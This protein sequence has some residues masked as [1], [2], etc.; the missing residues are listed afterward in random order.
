M[1]T[2]HP[3]KNL[4]TVGQSPVKGWFRFTVGASGAVGTIRQAKANH[5]KSITRTGA[6]AYTVEFYAPYPL[7]IVDIDF[8]INRLLVTNALR[9]VS[10]DFTNGLVAASGSTGATIKFFVSADTAVNNTA[11]VAT[12]PIQNTELMCEYTYQDMNALKD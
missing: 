12:D 1:T 6:G 7:N 4:K 5:I 3:T 10:Y 11:Q 9:Y 2:A 8:K